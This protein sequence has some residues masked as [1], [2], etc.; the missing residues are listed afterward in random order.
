MHT[1]LRRWKEI[2]CTSMNLLD[3]FTDKRTSRVLIRA[4]RE[5]SERCRVSARAYRPMSARLPVPRDVAR[6]ARG[7]RP[8]GWGR[9]GGWSGFLAH[10][11]HTRI[12]RT[13]NGR[14][15]SLACEVWL[16]VKVHDADSSRDGFFERAAHRG[17]AMHL[18]DDAGLAA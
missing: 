18:R 13:E 14:Q 8:L 2:K 5:R 17:V 16:V 1:F 6:I 3:F 9:K 7:A 12:P 15:L 4:P 11:I 10:P